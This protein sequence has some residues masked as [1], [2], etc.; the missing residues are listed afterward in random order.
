M[1]RA[2]IQDIADR[3]G[4]SRMTVSRALRNSPNVLPETRRRVLDAAEELAYRPHPLVASLMATVRAG[5]RAKITSETIAFVTVDSSREKWRHGTAL[6][7]YNGA[8]RRAGELGFRIEEFWIMEPGLTPDRASRILHTRN[9]HGLL[10]APA[11]LPMTAPSLDWE[12]FAAVAFGYSIRSPRL[13]RVANHQIHSVRLAVRTLRE[14]GYGRIGLAVERAADDRADN[15]WVSGFLFSYYSASPR[16]RLKP[17]VPDRLDEKG[18]KVWFERHRP[19][20]VL[21]GDLRIP[22]WLRELGLSIP[23]DVGF[24]NLDYYPEAGKMAGI[25]QNSP[26]IGAAAIELLAEQLYHNVRGIPDKPKALLVDSEW[27]EGPTVRPG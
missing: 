6:A 10:I 19:E 2:T 20:A 25:D 8:A 17:F 11:P 9:I 14:R 24:V 5:P 15:N 12:N 21:A 23:G 22:G 13:H 7:Y 4:V 18:F 27:V 26:A 1:H 16:H 3:A